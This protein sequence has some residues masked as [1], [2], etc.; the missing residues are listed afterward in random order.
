MYFLIIS[1]VSRSL[2]ESSPGPSALS[3]ALLP[4]APFL[5]SPLVFSCSFPV[6]GHVLEFCPSL[7]NRCEA[8]EASAPPGL[9]LA[10]WPIMAKRFGEW[11]WAPAWFSPLVTAPARSSGPQ[12]G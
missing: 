9:S 8:S 7:E 3:Q 12:L 10:P 2:Q 4:L 11:V 6:A 5:R 1:P